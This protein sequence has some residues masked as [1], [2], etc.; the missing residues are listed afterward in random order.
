MCEET[1]KLGDRL[2]WLATI[3]VRR[4]HFHH[5][6]CNHEKEIT[7]EC[8]LQGHSKGEDKRVSMHSFFAIWF[9]VVSTIS[10]IHGHS[11]GA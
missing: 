6:H 10:A 11:F 2:Y 1:E 5:K 9:V 7:L 4:V 8:L 3:E